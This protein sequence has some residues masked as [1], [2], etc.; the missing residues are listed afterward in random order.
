TETFRLDY[1]S[2]LLVLQRL[3]SLFG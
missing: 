2:A 1:Y 3:S